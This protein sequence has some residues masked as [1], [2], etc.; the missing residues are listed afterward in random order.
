MK[1]LFAQAALISTFALGAILGGGVALD[2]GTL[3][4]TGPEAA[5]A[6]MKQDPTKCWEEGDE[7]VWYKDGGWFQC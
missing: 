4:L 1:K 2:S 6:M 3:T 5:E 7:S